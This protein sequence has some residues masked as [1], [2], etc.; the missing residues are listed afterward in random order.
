MWF[1]DGHAAG[2]QNKMNKRIG[3]DALAELLFGMNPSSVGVRQKPVAHADFKQPARAPTET[4]MMQHPTLA[5]IAAAIVALQSNPAFAEEIEIIN[6]IVKSFLSGKLAELQSN[7]A[8]A[9]LQSNPYVQQLAA[10]PSNPAV[11][12]FWGPLFSMFALAYAVL[13]WIKWCWADP[14]FGEK[15][16]NPAEE[17]AAAFDKQQAKLEEMLSKRRNKLSLKLSKVN[18]TQTELDMSPKDAA[19]LSWMS[20]GLGNDDWQDDILNM[21]LPELTLAEQMVNKLEQISSKQLA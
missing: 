20:S 11:E 7:P 10:L 14:L 4:A 15:E 12:I 3:M 16:E 6:P 18:Q 13:G 9:D 17:E 1:V 19:Y 8:L 2:N 5:S 21:S